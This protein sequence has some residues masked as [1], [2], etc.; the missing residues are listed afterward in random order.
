[1]PKHKKRVNRKSEPKQKQSQKQVVNVRI[2]HTSLARKR[3]TYQQREIQPRHSSMHISH[4]INPSSTPLPIIQNQQPYYEPFQPLPI[5]NDLRVQEEPVRITDD[6]PTT[7]TS[8]SKV[9]KSYIEAMKKMR[10]DT[11]EGQQS[12][13][14]SSSSS[15]SSP[16]SSI[17]PQNNP[18]VSR[19]GN[20][21]TEEQKANDPSYENVNGKNLK[22]GGTAWKNA[23]K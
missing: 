15:S 22:I 2:N 3:R 21:L 5:R 11:R 13:S 12:A 7:S 10:E 9:Q 4:T 6:I 16:S 14:S 8:I 19:R 17:I 1:M 23:R 20:R 18:V